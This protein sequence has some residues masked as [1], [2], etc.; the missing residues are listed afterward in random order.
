MVITRTS[1][2]MKLQI[3][4]GIN[5]IIQEAKSNTYQN[6]NIKNQEINE[7]EENLIEILNTSKDTKT[8][9]EEDLTTAVLLFKQMGE[10]I[11]NRFIRQEEKGNV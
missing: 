11:E 9:I 3:V 7:A 6:L 8:N 10:E 4:E 1:E 2:Q 5:T